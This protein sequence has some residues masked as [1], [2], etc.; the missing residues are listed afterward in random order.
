MMEGLVDPN[1]CNF[2]PHRQT[3]DNIIIAHEVI[4]SMRHK[5]GKKRW[6]AIKIDIEKA[7]D[8]LS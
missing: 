5:K 4:H 3:T 2:V 7:Y 1:Q 6:M 8:R